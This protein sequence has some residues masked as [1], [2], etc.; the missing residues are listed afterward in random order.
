M[1]SLQSDVS[2]SSSIVQ[3]WIIGFVAFSAALLVVTG[4][5]WGA[6]VTPDSVQYLE[7]AWSFAEGHG[8]RDFSPHWP[9]LYPLL[10]SALSVVDGDLLTAVRW[11]NALLA[12]LN[13]GLLAKIT[14]R[15]G[16]SRELAA[17]F[18][19]L[20]SLQPGFLHVHYLLWS[21]PL[22][23]AFALVDLIMLEGVLRAPH[24]RELWFGLTSSVAAASLVRYAGLFLLFLNAMALLFAMAPGS[25]PLRARVRRVLVVSVV[26]VTPL[27]VWILQNRLHAGSAVNRSLAWHPPGADHLQM[28]GHTIATWVHLPD[29]VGLP[30]FLL[31]FVGSLL[32]IIRSVRGEAADWPMRALLPAY[33][34]AYSAFLAASITL[35]DYHIP[36]SERIL[37]PLLPIAAAILLQIA[38]LPARRWL[39]AVLLFP[40][41]FLFAIG[42]WIGWLDWQVARA[43]GL[44]LTSKRV[45][46]MPVLPWLAR[47]PPKVPIVSNGPELVTIYLHRNSAPLP[48]LYDPTTQAVNA[49]WQRQ[50]DST[51]KDGV[52][53][54]YFGAMS[55]RR[56][57]PGTQEVATL[58]RMRLIY[59]GPDS[60]VWYREPE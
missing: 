11:L 26:S 38:Q 49:D 1:A 27:L 47:L 36:L 17:V 59:E 46:S 53:I 2:A 39:S 31:L 20:L 51:T 50:L 24:R 43:E 29:I 8:F 6:G 58:S 48:R 42:G 10:L 54:V 3:R 12:A 41:L 32:L 25:L 44:G 23:L 37:F 55:W 34:L 57:F 45:Q 35:V 33:L 52:V 60:L 19:L 56:Y 9:P 14:V 5:P 16:W 4:T 30:L 21:E 13:I 18:L 15:S 7:A 40:L 22:F 28:L